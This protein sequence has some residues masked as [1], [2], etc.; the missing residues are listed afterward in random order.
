LK[1]LVIFINYCQSRLDNPVYRLFATESLYRRSAKL[2][3]L[4]KPLDERELLHEVAELRN[5]QKTLDDVTFHVCA[6]FE[7]QDEGDTVVNAIRLIRRL[8]PSDIDHHY[9]TFVYG[10]MPKLQET[11]EETVK[12]IWRNLVVVNNAVSDHIECRLLTNVYLYNDSSQK[13]LA[14]FIYYICHSNISF[15]KLSARIPVQQREL[16]GELQQESIDF[17]PI[18]GGFN[19]YGISYPEQDIR[20]HLH[21]YFL[22]SALRYSIPEVN[23]TQLEA[24]NF[25]AQR[26]LSNLPIQNQRITLQEESFLHLDVDDNTSWQRVDSFWEENVELQIHGLNDVPREDW[27]LKIRQRVDILYQGRFREIGT[28]YFFKL[29]NKKTE[30]YCRILSSIVNTEFEKAVKNNPY[31]PEAQKTIVRGMINILQQK[32]IELQKLKEGTLV[33]LRSIEQEIN[34]IKGKWNGLNIFNRLMGKDS[35]TLELYR[36]ALTRLMIQKSLIPGCDFAMKLLNELIPS[37]SALLEK[38]DFAQHIFGET[39]RNVESMVK[40]TNPTDQFGIFGTRELMQSRIAIESD[41]NKL[42]ELYQ[43][44]LGILYDANQ[45]NDADDFL[46]RLR[47]IANEDADI[48]IDKRIEECSIPPVLGVSIIDRI[49]RHSLGFGGIEQFVEK[50]MQETPVT[51]D[52][53]RNCQIGSK[54]VLIAPEMANKVEGIEHIVSEDFS[55]LQLLNLRYGLTLQDLEG[56]SG[57]RMFVEPSIF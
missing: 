21:Q 20:V 51:I 24:C 28:D 18:F 39:L 15:E 14:E 48:Y 3:F 54:F 16:F 5:K 4:L 17:P 12:T 22:Y 46:S 29:E 45:V 13:S 1:H 37:V 9:P 43:K 2:L 10:Q 36:N 33:N 40:E 52:I 8:F 57:Q 11:D 50:I 55:H 42:L 31:T 27:L 44:F 23:N 56:F 53:K 25:E 6:N 7:R 30:D 35:L 47:P 41:S 26:I 19:T 32:V 49:S 38:C 34:D